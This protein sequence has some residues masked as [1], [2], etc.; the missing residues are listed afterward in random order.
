MSYAFIER[1]D[2]IGSITISKLVRN[3]AH[4]VTTYGHLLEPGDSLTLHQFS[5]RIEKHYPSPFVQIEAGELRRWQACMAYAEDH[6][7]NFNALPVE[8]EWTDGVYDHDDILK[9]LGGEA[10]DWLTRKIGHAA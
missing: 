2:T 7:I 8:F 4:F 10:V 5:Y 1:P 3:G 6:V 9:I